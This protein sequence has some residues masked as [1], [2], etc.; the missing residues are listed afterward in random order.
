LILDNHS[1]HISNETRAWLATRPTGRFELTFTPTHGSW[2]NLIEGFLSK[3]TRSVL[4]HI[5]A[6]SK[7]ELKQR[8]LAGIRDIYR[9]PVIRTW[10]CKLADAV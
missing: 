2:L 4:R 9:R 5:R 10:S 7:I 1:A 8:I 3:L 6:T